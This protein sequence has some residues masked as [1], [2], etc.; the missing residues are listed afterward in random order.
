MTDAKR[1][2][3]VFLVA[4]GLLAGC[5]GS[6]GGPTVKALETVEVRQY[7]GE[8]L[9]SIGD[10]RENSIKGPQTVSLD[11]YH[12]KISGLVDNPLALTYDQVLA[13]DKYSKVV[14]LHC[15]EGWDVTILWEGVLID[16]L[17]KEAKAKDGATIAIFH[18]ADGY[19]SS[20]TL[21][22]IRRNKI[23]LAYKLNGV[24]M[25]PERGF[26]FMVVAE[27]KWGYKWVKWVTEIELSDNSNYQ[28]YWESQ[29]YNNNGD[30]S[31][32]MFGP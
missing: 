20:L 15:V 24:T 1:A 9:S 29:G 25:P 27:A 11:G 17:L 2:G 14:T 3:I 21:D 10:F 19:T 4:A 31:G 30:Q 6:G 26:P 16:D 28:G 8:N 23:L 7:Q 13:L 22:F 5:G 18:A 12:L 32:P